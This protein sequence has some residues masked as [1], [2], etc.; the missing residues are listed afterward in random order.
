MKSEFYGYIDDL[1]SLSYVRVG[2]IERRDRG[3]RGNKD[4]VYQ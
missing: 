3:L 2:L 4:L 1:V